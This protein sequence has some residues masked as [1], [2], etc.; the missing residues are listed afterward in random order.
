MHV[1]GCESASLSGTHSALQ[2]PFWATFK[3]QHGWQ[4]HAFS[5]TDED[6]VTDLLVLTRRLF[7]PF[8]VAYVPFGP[9]GVAFEQ[10]Y[11]LALQLKRLLP[12]SVFA[13]RLDLPFG[14]PLRQSYHPFCPCR[15]SVQPEATIRIDLRD[16][17][18]ALRAS[19]RMRA[20]RSLR[21][22]EEAG[23]VIEESRGLGA[24][25]ETFYALYRHTAEREGFLPRSRSYLESLV[26][27]GSDGQVSLISASLAGSMVAAIIVLYGQREAI[28][29]IGAS[30]RL[31]SLSPSYALQD[32]AIKV[33]CERNLLWYDLYGVGGPDGRDRHLASLEHFKR[34]FGGSRVERP[35]TMDLPY[36]TLLWRLYRFAEGVR[37]LLIGARR[38]LRRAL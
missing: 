33:A 25:F 30:R 1:R 2:S 36:R 31:D 27:S 7:G 20:R 5:I 16:G 12:R 35:A 28:Y 18:P 24:H 29:L 37:M 38:A 8:S 10:L 4:A 17:Y 13:L 15:H 11:D 9:D 23:L 22:L 14:A 19:Y 26:V 32:R 21:R 3:A 6:R 34:S